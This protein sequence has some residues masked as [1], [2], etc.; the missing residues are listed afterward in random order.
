MPDFLESLDVL[1]RSIVTC[2]TC[3]RHASI[4]DLARE[5]GIPH[6]EI[7][8]RLTEVIAPQSRKILANHVVSF[9]N[10]RIDWVT[11]EKVI[12]SWWIDSRVPLYLD[13][14]EVFDDTDSILLITDVP[15]LNISEPIK[16]QVNYRNG[17]LQIKLYKETIA[18]SVPSP[19]EEE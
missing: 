2:L 18:P 3:R 6:H 14:K 16:S 4:D 9:E 5:T 12:L 8:R 19:G 10:A 13:E 11:G 15:G 1:S 7:L 17:V